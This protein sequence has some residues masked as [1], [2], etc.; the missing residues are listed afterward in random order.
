[1]GQKK[2][3]NV[4]AKCKYYMQHYVFCDGQYRWAYLGHCT[5]S[6]LKPRQPSAKAC[7]QYQENPP[8]PAAR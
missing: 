8:D 6:R 7:E 4:C 2:Q 5:Q 1:M 3:D